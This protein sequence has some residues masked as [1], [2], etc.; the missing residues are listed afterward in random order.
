MKHD[1]CG[2]GQ[3]QRI[4]FVCIYLTERA[5]HDQCIKLLGNAYIQQYRYCKTFITENIAEEQTFFCK[6]RYITCRVFELLQMNTC[7]G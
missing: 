4:I 6:Y 2:M 3:T 1:K 5:N 7:T